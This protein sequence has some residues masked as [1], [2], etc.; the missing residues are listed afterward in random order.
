MS[1]ILCRRTTWELDG[2]IV[3]AAHTIAMLLVIVLLF[4]ISRFRIEHLWLCLSVF[5]CGE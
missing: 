5:E 1:L 4:E 3:R 2:G